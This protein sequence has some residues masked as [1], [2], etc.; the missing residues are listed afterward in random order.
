[1]WGS[2]GVKHQLG[3]AA[4]HRHEDGFSVRLVLVSNPSRPEAA[5]PVV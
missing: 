1:M 3:Y 4:E 2:G 5:G